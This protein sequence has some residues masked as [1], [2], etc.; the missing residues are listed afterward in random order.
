MWLSY[1]CLIKGDEGKRRIN[2]ISHQASLMC[3]RYRVVLNRDKAVA[4]KLSLSGDEDER[5]V[6]LKKK[7]QKIYGVVPDKFYAKKKITQQM[8]LRNINAGKEVNFYKREE[9]FTSIREELCQEF[10]SVLHVGF[11]RFKVFL[12]QGKWQKAD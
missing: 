1:Y 10:R 4:R 11:C 9:V 2:G 8:R 5:E 6:V 12:L 3:D 7:K